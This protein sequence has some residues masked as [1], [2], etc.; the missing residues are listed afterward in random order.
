MSSSNWQSD[1]EAINREYNDIT[2]IPHPRP[3]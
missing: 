3:Q 2:H 1:Q